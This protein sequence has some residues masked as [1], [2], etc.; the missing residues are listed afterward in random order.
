MAGQI[1]S[2]IGSS[3]AWLLV[4]SA[5][6]ALGVAA[7]RL[8]SWVWAKY[9]APCGFGTKR[10]FVWGYRG[11]G[12][13]AAVTAAAVLAGVMRARVEGLLIVLVGL[14]TC[15]VSHHVGRMHWQASGFAKCVAYQRS[16][17]AVGV[18][19]VGLGALILAS[20]ALEN[21]LGQ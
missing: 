11:M 12:L 20:Q 7:K 16:W 18:G 19:W 13:L 21:R 5:G 10:A 8:G 6:L 14:Q 9:G 2:T 3:V 4:G 17:L 15:M 1:D